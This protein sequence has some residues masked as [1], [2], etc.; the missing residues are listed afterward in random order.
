[1]PPRRSPYVTDRPHDR[2][3]NPPA[4]LPDTLLN[5]EGPFRTPIDTAHVDPWSEAQVEMQRISTY[6]CH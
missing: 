4:V 1:M 2:H 6:F 5:E 3:Q